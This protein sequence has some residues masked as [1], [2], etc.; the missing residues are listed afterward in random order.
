[1]AEAKERA[2]QILRGP[3]GERIWLE[4]LDYAHKRARR[5]GWRTDKSLPQGRSPGGIAKDVIIKVLEGNRTWDETREPSLLNAL[6]GMV[7][8]D[9][10]HAFDEYETSNVESISQSLPDG[11]ERTAN[12]FA[13]MDPNPEQIFLQNEQTRLEMTA[14]DL[15]REQVEGKAE[16]ESVFLALYESSDCQEIARLTD[17]P[18]ERVYSLRRELD[19]IASRIT[20]AR[21][22]REARARRKQ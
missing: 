11:Q 9:I 13:A 21:V 19:R 1:M 10:G 6:K 5:Y 18:I 2:A 22:A 4:L 8:S 7:R 14:L 12:S 16:L 20:P 3:D 15:I 17:L